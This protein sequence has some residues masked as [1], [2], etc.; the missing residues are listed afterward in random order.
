MTGFLQQKS[1]FEGTTVR[2]SRPSSSFWD[3]QASLP[4]LAAANKARATGRGRLPLRQTW[5]GSRDRSQKSIMTWRPVAAAALYREGH[6]VIPEAQGGMSP[7][8][9]PAEPDYEVELRENDAGALV[10]C[11]R[12]EVVM[13]L[14][15]PGTGDRGTYS[16]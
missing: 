15:F 8:R 13:L 7:Q 16:C 11:C 1:L 10:R 3:W 6:A 4:P 14:W 12:L 5:R 9:A 2:C